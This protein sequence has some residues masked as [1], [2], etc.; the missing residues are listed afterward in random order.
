LKGSSAEAIDGMDA[1]ITWAVREIERRLG[2][3]LDVPDLAAS[4]NLSPSRF[5]YLFQRD[6]GTSPARFVRVRRLDRARELLETTFLSV[7]E[8]MVEV[9]LNDASHFTRDFRR[10]HGLTP[11]AWRQTR[12][13]R[14]R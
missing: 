13:S 7:K 11:R 1:R 5:A 12:R 8:V 9:G 2:A 6:M 14:P 3:R 4:V 10:Q